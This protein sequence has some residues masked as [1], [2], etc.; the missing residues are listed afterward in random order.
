MKIT[1]SKR[2][3]IVALCAL[4]AG[5]MVYV[6]FLRY[7]YYDQMCILF[8]QYKAIVPAAE[9]NEFIGD[10]GLAFGVVS[11]LGYTFGGILADK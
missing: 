3:V 6:P 5:V 8:T 2:W 7:S 11:M 10:F 4:M 1:G 9:V